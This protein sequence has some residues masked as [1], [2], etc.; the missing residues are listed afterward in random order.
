MRSTPSTLFSGSA[1]IAE[2]LQKMHKRG[3]AFVQLR[4]RARL[5]SLVDLNGTNRK[6]IT[7]NLHNGETLLSQVLYRLCGRSYG[8][9][10]RCVYMGQDGRLTID[11]PKP[12]AD[13]VN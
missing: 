11:Y 9:P 4:G 13:W 6:H 7:V 3:R 10:P 12:A 2:I 8:H 1:V 5:L